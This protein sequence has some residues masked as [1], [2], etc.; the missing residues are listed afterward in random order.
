MMNWFRF[1]FLTALITVATALSC[2]INAAYAGQDS[3]PAP[4]TGALNAPTG[5]DQKTLYALGILMSRSLSPFNLAPAELEIVKQGLTDAATGKKTAVDVTAYSEKVQ[6]LFVERRKA[7]GKK[8]AGMDNGF[9]DK[10]AREKGAVK[11][12]SGLI[13]RSLKDGKGASPSP[14]DTVKVNYTG[15]FPDGRELDSSYKRGTPL[16]FKMETVLKCWKEGLQKMKTGGKAKLVCPSETAY[17]EA[18]QGD[19]ILP[20]ATLVFEVELLE[21]KK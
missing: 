21:I 6:D 14:T 12:D 7:E 18:G 10:A 17:G 15:S 16:E 19:L 1:L 13:Y 5:E 8:M 9:L 20:Y 3:A 4:Q 2:G 11:T